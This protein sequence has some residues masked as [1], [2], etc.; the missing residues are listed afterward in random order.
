MLALLWILVG[1]GIGAAAMVPLLW[2][3]PRR[4]EARARDAERRARDAERLA[5][6]G[7]M[8]GGLAH[9]IK[10]PLSTVGLN[11]QLLAESISESNLPDDERQRLLRRLEALRREV[12]RLRDILTDFLQF[13]GRI[14]L[15]PQPHNLIEVLNELCDFFHPQCEQEGV[16][17]RAQLPEAEWTVEIDEGLFKQAVLNLLINAV[18]AIKRAAGRERGRHQ[19]IGEIIMRAD[20]HN[21]HA[22]VHVIDTG[23]GIEPHRREEIFRPYV[24]GRPGGTGLGLPIARRI[25]EEHGGRLLLDSEVGRGSDFQIQVPMAQNSRVR[26]ADP[27]G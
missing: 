19:V 21:G 15:D 14:R 7:A 3:L 23:P 13:A 2:L 25:V 11:A 18:Q 17:L 22:C 12:D 9:E 6:L 26:H 8:T 27:S 5:E 20:E 24:S 1:V 4:A 16:L 10:N